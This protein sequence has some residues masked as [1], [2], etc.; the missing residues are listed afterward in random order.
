MVTYFLTKKQNY[1]GGTVKKQLKDRKRNNNQKEI[2]TL[3]PH[4][5]FRHS[6]KIAA[7]RFSCV[8]TETCSQYNPE[9]TYHKQGT[10]FVLYNF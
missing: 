3:I 7:T 10:F 6:N 9:D 4:P 5:P 1:R 8:E 2:G